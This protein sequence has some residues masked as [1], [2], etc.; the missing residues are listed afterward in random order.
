MHHHQCLGQS[1]TSLIE[2]AQ[3]H[4]RAALAQAAK[5]GASRHAVCA[6]GA[7]SKHGCTCIG[8]MGTQGEGSKL[9]LE[10]CGT[11]GSRLG[12]QLLHGQAIQNFD[13]S[14]L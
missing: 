7:D 10:M 2:A 6:V 9:P 4:I 11:A 14:Q 1:T 12:L 5:L 3:R 13:T 8:G